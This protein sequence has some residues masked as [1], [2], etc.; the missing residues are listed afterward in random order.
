MRIVKNLFIIILLTSSLYSFGVRDGSFE[1]YLDNDNDAKYDY[2]FYQYLKINFDILPYEKIR[3]FFSIGNKLQPFKDEDSIKVLLWSANLTYYFKNDIY[4]G[5]GDRFINYS[6]YTIHLEEWND[7]VFKGLFFHYESQRYNV[8][9]DGFVGLHSEETNRIKYNGEYLRTDAGFIN[10]YY[11]DRIQTESPTIWGGFKLKKI[12]NDFF[13]TELIYVRENYSLE[14]PVT[15]FISYYFFNN[16]IFQLACDFEYKKKIFLNLMP[17]IMNKSFIKYNGAGDFYGEGRHKLQKDYERSVVEKAG[18]ARLVIHDLYD[19]YLL[20]GKFSFMYRYI[21]EEFNPVHM[22]NGRLAEGRGEN[23]LDDLLVGEKG[24]IINA[25]IPLL[26]SHFWGVEF[27]EY[28]HIRN[29]KKYLDKRYY[30]KQNFT[31]DFN[32]LFM[33]RSQQGYLD[34]HGMINDLQG[35]VIRLDGKLMRYFNLQLW[36]VEHM[37]YQKNNNEILLKGVLKF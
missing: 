13:D 6:P 10:K 20:N 29:D 34:E 15:D 9:F 4:I 17:A 3:I 22:D 8:D 27:Q 5:I 19:F 35:L 28:N 11:I 36:F 33:L 26:E 24:F 14:R 25:E 12:W 18:E 30:I 16:D 31:E 21:E 32:L 37:S 7:N 2:N 23:F 1:F